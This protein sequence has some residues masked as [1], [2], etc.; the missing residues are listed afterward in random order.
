MVLVVV[1]VVVSVVVAVL[2]VVVAV[3]VIVIIVG[4]A[5][6]IVI[7]DDC[8]Q[9]MEMMMSSRLVCRLT[10]ADRPGCVALSTHACCSEGVMKTAGTSLLDQCLEWWRNCGLQ[11]S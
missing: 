5:I 4:I 9:I 10:I 11:S 3:I 2:V 7:V 1:A 8:F 6:A